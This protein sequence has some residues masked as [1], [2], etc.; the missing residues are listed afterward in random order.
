M[1]SLSHKSIILFICITTY[2]GGEGGRGAFKKLHVSLCTS[3]GLYTMIFI[4]SILGI[5][6]RPLKG[7][8]RLFM[9]GIN[10]DFNVKFVFFKP[11]FSI[12]AEHRT[13]GLDYFWKIIKKTEVW[14]CCY[15][16]SEI[17]YHLLNLKVNFYTRLYTASSPQIGALD[18][19]ALNALETKLI[20]KQG[21]TLAREEILIFTLGTCFSIMA[22]SRTMGFDLSER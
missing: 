5:S 22:E 18:S 16:H 14:L 7:L 3:I 17:R 13:M 11:I 9:H 19:P 15:V 8:S 10:E 20:S 12:M 2:I 1:F 6:G 21:P 4:S